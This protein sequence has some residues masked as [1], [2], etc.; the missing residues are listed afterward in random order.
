MHMAAY[1]STKFILKFKSFYFKVPRACLQ[2][3]A[4]LP[5]PVDPEASAVRPLSWL[6]W[7]R[8]SSSIV[9]SVKSP[10]TP[11]KRHRTLS[12]A[13]QR[14]NSDPTLSPETLPLPLSALRA[15]RKS[16]LP[17]VIKQIPVLTHQA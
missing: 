7:P 16:E 14:E 3:C 8:P 6:L 12:P 13:S 11:E 10:E 17:I 1:E 2:M 4:C 9:F 5:G 15:P